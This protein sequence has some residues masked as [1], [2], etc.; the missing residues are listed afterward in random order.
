MLFT[1]CVSWSATYSGARNMFFKSD[2]REYLVDPTWIDC[3]CW[4]VFLLFVLIIVLVLCER[5][6]ILKAGLSVAYLNPGTSSPQSGNQQALPKDCVNIH[7]IFRRGLNLLPRFEFKVASLWTQ[8]LV[9]LTLH[10]GG[11]S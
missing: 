4:V 3:W 2:L 6:K 11:V 5:P 7:N 8:R 1:A 9:Q 10:L